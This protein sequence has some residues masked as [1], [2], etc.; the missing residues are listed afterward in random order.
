MSNDQSN[1]DLTA[2]PSNDVEA[3]GVRVRILN[4]EE[5]NED[6]E[7]HVF[8]PGGDAGTDRDDVEGHLAR[9]KGPD[10]D[11]DSDSDVEGHGVRIKI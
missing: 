11:A 9:V 3:H 8:R 1:E 10:T 4:D 7:G 5:K 2:A 6:V